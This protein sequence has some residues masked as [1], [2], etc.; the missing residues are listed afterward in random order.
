MYKLYG[1]DTKGGI[2]EW[3]VEV[4]GNEVVVTH[5]K[6]GGKM[7]TKVTA[8]SGKNIGR[9]NETTPEQQ[10][11]LEATS[12]YNKQ[13]DKLYRH[14]IEELEEVGHQLPMLAHDYTKVGHR[15]VWPCY[16]SAKLDGVRCL[17]HISP[18]RI[19]LVSRGGKQ[20][21]VPSHL[22]TQ[23]KRLY[24]LLEPSTGT[25]VLDGE[26]YIHGLPLQEIVSCVKKEN[27][28]TINLCFCVFDIPSD[29]V[30]SDRYTELLKI[31][32]LATDDWLLNIRVVEN[33]IADDEEAA[34]SAL[35]YFMEKGFEGIMLRNPNGTYLYNHRSSDLMKWKEFQDLEAK[36][37]GVARDKL[38]EGILICKM[39]DGIEV[40]CKMRGT[41]SYRAYD[42][43]MTLV[44][45]WITIRYQQLTV[46]GVPQFPVGIAVRDCDEDGNPLT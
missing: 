9:A 18:D 43:M 11:I 37:I 2:K 5:G 29:K 40:R 16:V 13:L 39:K 27:D 22:E 7:Q 12:K 14:T 30:W 8:C 4:S 33:F 26:L 38:S 34:K 46:D 35:Q 10:A 19:E 15:M 25:L 41:H 45:S 44:G 24:E 20:Y 23:L 28:N 6:L 1:K 21:P 31:A 17:A 42:N 3:S 36:V 32:K